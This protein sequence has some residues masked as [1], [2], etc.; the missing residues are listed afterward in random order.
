MA[1]TGH[2]ADVVRSGRMVSIALDHSSQDGE[3]G[4]L[5]MRGKSLLALGYK[6]EQDRQNIH[7]ARGRR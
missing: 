2:A 3:N 1:P 5:S 4:T 7:S 6:H